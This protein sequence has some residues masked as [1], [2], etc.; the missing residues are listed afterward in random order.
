MSNYLLGFIGGRGSGK[1]SAVRFAADILEANGCATNVVRPSRLLEDTLD[2]W[3]LDRTT[4]NL[5]KLSRLLRE[6]FGKNTI[7]NAIS[8]ILIEREPCVTL[9][10]G[11]RWYEDEQYV[12]SMKPSALIYLKTDKRLRFQRISARFEKFEE[13]NSK[14]TLDKFE[15]SELEENEAYI[16]DIGTRADYTI[17]NSKSIIDLILAHFQIM[18]SIKITAYLALILWRGLDI[19]HYS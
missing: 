19:S 11:I 2:I 1:S 5:Q 18:R 17:D 9:W 12:R 4:S 10:D 3:H 14:I 7:P 13:I 16:A 6:E 8:R 15:L